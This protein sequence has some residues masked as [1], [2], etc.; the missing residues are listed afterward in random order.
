MARRREE[1]IARQTASR[2]M[3]TPP[4]PPAEESAESI[5]APERDAAELARL[6]A[7]A[8][9]LITAMRISF[10]ESTARIFDE[11]LAGARKLVKTKAASEGIEVTERALRIAEIDLCRH[12]LE[13]IRASQ[14]AM[15]EIKA[16]A[17]AAYLTRILRMT[18]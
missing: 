7:E 4:E 17:Y 8:N 2:T 13:M 9:E 15:E 14:A 18:C 12:K 6:T 3:A 1:E 10:P 5:C 11:K 16:R